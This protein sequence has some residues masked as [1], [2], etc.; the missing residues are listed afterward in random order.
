MTESLLLDVIIGL[1]L[2]Y[3]LTGIIASSIA[4]GFSQ[5]LKLRGENLKEGIHSILDGTSNSADY[6]RLMKDNSS[7]GAAF[8][9]HPLINSISRYE[10]SWPSE[11][12]S[13][14]FVQVVEDIIFDRDSALRST[15][16][17]TIA[18]DGLKNKKVEL[19]KKKENNPSSTIINDQIKS[20]EH[21]ISFLSAIIAQSNGNIDEFRKNLAAYYDEFATRIISWY[22]RNITYWIW[23]IS[24]TICLFLNLD[25]IQ[26]AKTLYHNP[27]L[28]DKLL[29][30]VN[31]IEKDSTRKFNALTSPIDSLN[32]N[33]ENLI[34]A[35]IALQTLPIGWSSFDPKLKKC[36][37][38]VPYFLLKF[39]GIL[40]TA[41]A[42]S[43]GSDFWYKV[44]TN[45]LKL[46]SSKE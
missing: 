3:I 29:V 39:I 41:I 23:G 6:K 2:V 46:R 7:W 19:E 1:T 32:Q 40:L 34:E 45:L 42:A 26:I 33:K 24:F 44:L 38:P 11:I 14:T 8:Y 10:K 21:L 9:N 43:F 16:N 4:E 20:L 30:V 17:L 25:S 37:N 5:F 28:T 22:K 27:V 31:K 18:L 15:G 13:T 36:E 12:N 35:Y